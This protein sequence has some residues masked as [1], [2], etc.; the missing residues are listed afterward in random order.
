VFGMEGQ[1][2]SGDSGCGGV[3]RV[4]HGEGIRQLE[5]KVSQDTS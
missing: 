1:E 2:G 4:T 3:L 5:N